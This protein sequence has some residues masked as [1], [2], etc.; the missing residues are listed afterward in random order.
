MS[1]SSAITEAAESG[2]S[3]NLHLILC[4]IVERIAQIGMDRLHPLVLKAL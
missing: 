4:F 1:S 2:N 3:G